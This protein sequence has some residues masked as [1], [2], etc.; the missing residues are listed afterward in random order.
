MYVCVRMC[1][2]IC[3]CVFVKLL[4]PTLNSGRERFDTHKHIHT[5]KIL[6]YFGFATSHTSHSFVDL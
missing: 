3:V 6:V 2:Y 5:H 1:A 4:M